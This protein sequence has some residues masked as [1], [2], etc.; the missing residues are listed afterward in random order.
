M[1][2]TSTCNALALWGTSMWPY[3]R[4]RATGGVRTSVL[5]LR[6]ESAII[7]VGRSLGTSKRLESSYRAATKQLSVT[8][9]IFSY[10]RRTLHAEECQRCFRGHSARQNVCCFPAFSP[11]FSPTALPPL[12]MNGL[13]PLPYSRYGSSTAWRRQCE[14]GR[15]LVLSVLLGHRHRHVHVHTP[16]TSYAALCPG[17]ATCPVGT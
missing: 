6:V 5:Q 7:T 16:P 2:A 17:S 14:E 1:A 3:E 9:C 10:V 15:T 13:T 8:D 11:A 4:G 12:Y